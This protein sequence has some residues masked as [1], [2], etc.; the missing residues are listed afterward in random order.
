MDAAISARLQAPAR[1]LPESWCAHRHLALP[2]S[3]CT[4]AASALPAQRRC[5]S[6]AVA[7]SRE[8]AVQVVSA[9]ASAQRERISSA[10]TDAEDEDGHHDRRASSSASDDVHVNAFVARKAT[11]E[12]IQGCGAIACLRSDK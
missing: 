2:G 6:V 4:H 5:R 8:H 3:R 11:F 12:R 9:S 7:A 1:T 10:G